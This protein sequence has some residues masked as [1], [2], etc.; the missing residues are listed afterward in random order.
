MIGYSISMFTATHG[1]LARPTSGGGFTNTKSI[2][3]DGID[4]YVI[5]ETISLN[6]FKL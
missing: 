6:Y 5:V 2:L 4:D 3:L 1:I